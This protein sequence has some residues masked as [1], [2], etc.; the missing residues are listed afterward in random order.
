MAQGG[1]EAAHAEAALRGQLAALAAERDQL[2]Q[3]LAARTEAARELLR[4]RRG[5]E[6]E[7]AALR[8]EVAQLRERALAAEGP[9]AGCAQ[10][11][12]RALDALEGLPLSPDR[13]ESPPAPAPSGAAG[14]P[15]ELLLHQA[16]AA[17]SAAEA[18]TWQRGPRAGAAQEGSPSPREASRE[19]ELRE[20]AAAAAEGAAAAEA[21]ERRLRERL[22][23]TQAELDSVSAAAAD[24]RRRAEAAEAAAAEAARR[25]QAGAAAAAEVAAEAERLRGEVAQLRESLAEERSRGAALAQAAACRQ[26]TAAAPLRGALA[27]L[28]SLSLMAGSGS[29]AE[30]HAAR[31]QGLLADSERE[32]DR[33]R[34][35]GDGT[36]E[37][38]RA[39]ERALSATGGALLRLS[40]CAP[41]N[42][43][44]HALPQCLAAMPGRHGAAALRRALLALGRVAR[45]DQGPPPAQLT[46]LYARAAAH[47]SQEPARREAA[48]A[49]GALRAALRSLST[50]RIPATQLGPPPQPRQG[51][52]GD[53]AVRGMLRQALAA[54][55]S[56]QRQRVLGPDG[57]GIGAGLLGSAGGR[58]PE[59]DLADA[60]A[61]GDA[62]EE[63]LRT[64][65]GRVAEL[66]D[67]LAGMRSQLGDAAQRLVRE[68]RMQ[69]AELAAEV[70]RLQGQLDA[71]CQSA[72][73]ARE[74]SAS[75][76]GSL[77][78]QLAETASGCRKLSACS[79]RLRPEMAAS[80]AGALRRALSGLHRAHPLAVA[81]A[82][83]AAQPAGQPPPAAP[84]GDGGGEGLR[85]I[86]T[87]GTLPSARAPTEVWEVGDDGSL[88]PSHAA[89]AAA[90]QSLRRC[91]SLRRRLREASSA[92]EQAHRD[93]TRTLTASVQGSSQQ[94]ALPPR[95]GA[96]PLPVGTF[97]VVGRPRSPPRPPLQPGGA[98][99]QGIPEALSRGAGILRTDSRRALRRH[100][101]PPAP[102]PGAA[103][104]L[105]A[106]QQELAG[107][108]D[109][110]A[111]L[112]EEAASWLASQGAASAASAALRRRLAEAEAASAR[113]HAQRSEAAEAAAELR[114]SAALQRRQADTLTSQVSELQ[115]Q[116]AAEQQ[117]R[118]AQAAADRERLAAERLATAQ[119]LDDLRSQ[120]D[121]AQTAG[122]LRAAVDCATSPRLRSR[123]CSRACSP[124][125]SFCTSPVGGPPS[126]RG[127]PPPPAADRAPPGASG[128]APPGRSPDRE[129]RLLAS[130][131][132][133]RLL[134]EE[135]QRA[136]AELRTAHQDASAAAARDALEVAVRERDAYRAK[137]VQ[138][139]SAQPGA[140]GDARRRFAAA[141][142]ARARC[143]AAARWLW[144]WALAAAGRSRAEALRLGS[145]N[146]GL[147]S[148]LRCAAADLRAARR[149]ASAAEALAAARGEAV[150]R[151]EADLRGEQR[152]R[153]G[154]A[155]PEAASPR[156]RAASP[157]ATP[158]SPRGSPGP[159]PR[160]GGRAGTTSPVHAT[161]PRRG[162]ATPGA[163][164]AEWLQLPCPP[165]ARDAAHCRHAAHREEYLQVEGPVFL[166]PASPQSQDASQWQPDGSGDLRQTPHR[167]RSPA[168]AA[169]GRG[170][171]NGAAELLAAA[172]S[173][174][175]EYEVS[176]GDEAAL[177][178]PGY[179][180][181]HRHSPWRQQRGGRNRWGPPGRG[182]PANGA[183]CSA[184]RSVSATPP[185]RSGPARAPCSNGSE[186]HRRAA[187][188]ERR[189][190]ARAAQHPAA[191]SGICWRA[192]L[193]APHQRSPPRRVT[194]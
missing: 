15:A 64:A 156:K 21:A 59:G 12:R 152:R 117:Q 99:Q 27:A 17:L 83:R 53:T 5:A 173:L 28:S 26:E 181:W 58:E 107:S 90:Q 111:Q 130:E 133:E 79:P 78:L 185:R 149:N 124:M 110:L 37:R 57:L 60:L 98:P 56:P 187:S 18:L 171:C 94:S 3:E 166:P 103:E 136:R 118:G 183:A 128:A 87:G 148:A 135:L 24:W 7:A 174:P 65:I 179:A 43:L 102:S 108:F 182:H 139:R 46:D 77:W 145:V 132:R 88:S 85:R 86:D 176:D 41:P 51:A 106:L 147:S 151:L 54:L 61:R 62:L 113:L 190:A 4:A 193:R 95:A 13:P 184:A 45:S 84:G 11:L 114:A 73:A 134:E 161:P 119:M 127:S 189:A 44:L 172:A 76:P 168:S 38:L 101:P 192:S 100:A 167:P 31:L 69:S 2:Q 163:A 9:G 177:W 191:A 32:V 169:P 142:G 42:V 30:L 1:P 188:V 158:G 116:L 153:H 74:A 125:P 67:H 155:T 34:A 23:S 75:G 97:E 72:A 48:G 131:A 137:C 82:G 150:S 19:R 123:Q 36:A 89:A 140:G 194:R 175:R 66:E 6:G 49:A 52:D 165:H 33:L 160:R 50:V 81:A 80:A 8:E 93:L 63:Q 164:Q 71:A 141:L 120:L 162:S 91:D 154:P 126:E 104:A 159:S 105:A 40:A 55:S 96:P 178:H 16:L 115:T 22:E 144:R 68:Q 29:A 14:R 25:S 112:R 10:L 143:A 180:E 92:A 122:R 20:R 186:E 157:A 39:A 35:E 170:A 146:Q 129:A 138:L 121:Q 70:R 47:R 109:D